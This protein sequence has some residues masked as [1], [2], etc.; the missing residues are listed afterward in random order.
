MRGYHDPK[1]VARV[2]FEHVVY[3]TKM[4]VMIYI[5]VYNG[6]AVRITFVYHGIKTLWSPCM[7]FPTYSWTPRDFFYCPRPSQS[8][9]VSYVGSWV[10]NTMVSLYGVSNTQLAPC[11]AFLKQ[12]FV[13]GPGQAEV[14]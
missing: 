4:K 5:C 2:I 3:K 11:M 7:E 14:V 10:P 12:I 1:S 13:P 9:V 6:D 8:E